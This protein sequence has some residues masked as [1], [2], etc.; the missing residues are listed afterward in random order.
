MKKTLI[1]VAVLAAAGAGSVYYVGEY[2]QQQVT[3]LIEQTNQQDNGVNA[4][5]VNYDKG[6]LAAQSQIELTFENPDIAEQKWVLLVDGDV[7]HWPYKAVINSKVS[8][9]DE[10]SKEVVQKLFGTTAPFTAQDEINLLGQLQGHAQLAPIDLAEGGNTVSM[11]PVTMT[12]SMNLNEMSGQSLIELASL[13][14]SSQDGERFVFKDFKVDGDFAQIAGSS[15]MTYDYLFK[16]AEAEVRTDEA[17]ADFTQVTMQTAFKQGSQANT[18]DT[19]L[20]LTVG[21]YVLMGDELLAFSNT[22]FELNVTG[23]DET[24]LLELSRLQTN[25]E[26]IDEALAQQLVFDLV[27]KGA[28]VSVSKLTSQTPWGDVNADININLPAGAIDKTILMRGPQAALGYISASANARMS[29]KFLEIPGIG[30]Q[31]NVAMMLGVLAQNGEE[32]VLKGSLKDGQL[33][34]NDNT[35]PLPGM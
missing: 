25:P 28:N 13:N 8:V 30:D 24:A 15:L 22:A 3:A 32:L 20:G 34:V 33:V 6:F 21:N 26:Q 18:L 31:L 11:T 23:L 17:N 4:K 16:I 9:T 14:I 27:G 7:Q 29:N 2:T 10:T 5:L 35:F 12:Y 19:L 1:A